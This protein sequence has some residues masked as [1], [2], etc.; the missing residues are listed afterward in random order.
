[1]ISQ[2]YTRPSLSSG[3]IDSTRSRTPTL[4][5]SRSGTTPNALSCSPT[6]TTIGRG[7]RRRSRRNSN[8]NL[9]PLARFSPDSRSATSF[10]EL[11]RSDIVWA[12]DP[13]DRFCKPLRR[14]GRCEPAGELGCGARRNWLYWRS[15]RDDAEHAGFR[16]CVCCDSPRRHCSSA[17]G[18]KQMTDM[19]AMFNR[20]PRMSH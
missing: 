14:F 7:R 4:T 16:S 12:I 17:M 20:T 1:V 13:E 11:D 6:N 15:V 8:W 18:T 3:T 2:Q 19:R 9:T 5:T 10:D